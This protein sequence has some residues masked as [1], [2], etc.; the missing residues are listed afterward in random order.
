MLFK[1]ID[2]AFKP[3]DL[4]FKMLN[5]CVRNAELSDINSGSADGLS[6]CCSVDK[7]GGVGAYAQV[8]MKS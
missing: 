1:L 4:A 6:Y 5:I 2:F 8:I 7:Y 3:I